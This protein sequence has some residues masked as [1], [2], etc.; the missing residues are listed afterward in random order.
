[1]RKTIGSGA[2]AIWLLREFEVE[3]RSRR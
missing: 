2:A 3:G 1:V